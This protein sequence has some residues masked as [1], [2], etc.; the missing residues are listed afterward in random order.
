M[1]K[2]GLDKGRLLFLGI[3]DGALYKHRR[4]AMSDVI[5]ILEQFEPSEVFLPY[6]GDRHPDHV[7]THLI[8][9]SALR[10]LG[11]KTLLYQ[12][13]V[14][15]IPTPN[16]AP[17]LLVVDISDVLKAKKAAIWQYESQVTN[18]LY[19]AQQRPVLRK[20]FVDRFYSNRETFILGDPLPLSPLNKVRLHLWLS[21]T[22]ALIT[23]FKHLRRWL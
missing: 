7:A 14:W 17:K 2:L 1:H 15:A 19:P 20:E 4:E 5:K 9:R 16:V 6:I 8:V 10:K 23:F 18:K 3:E 11:R 13:F 12:Y 21:L 22:S